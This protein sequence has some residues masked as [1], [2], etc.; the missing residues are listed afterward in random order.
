MLRCPIW[1]GYSTL[2]VNAVSPRTWPLLA[3]L[4]T[5][6]LGILNR[7][8]LGPIYAMKRV[9]VTLLCCLVQYPWRAF[10][11]GFAVGFC[12]IVISSP[13][14]QD[15]ASLTRFAPIAYSPAKRWLVSQAG[16]LSCPVPR[17]LILDRGTAMD[18]Y[19][20]GRIPAARS[21][22]LRSRVLDYPVSIAICAKNLR[23][24]A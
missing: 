16:N 21:G 19:P 3:L 9:G 13:F 14:D 4:G 22:D 8:Q 15:W 20:I 10:R 17:A 23:A 7:E 11:N 2:K 5:T 18:R 1:P 24:T 6:G 12:F